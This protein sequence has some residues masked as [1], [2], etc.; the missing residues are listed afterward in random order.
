MPKLIR[1]AMLRIDNHF[2]HFLPVMARIDLRQLREI[3]PE[4]H[5]WFTDCYRP[6]GVVPPFI[7]GFD[8]VKLWD[9][10][11]E[12]VQKA[13]TLFPTP[14]V[15]CAERRE[16]TRDVDA[17]FINN[18]DLD[19]SDH[20]RLAEPFIKRGIPTYIDKPFALSTRDAVAMVKLARRHRTPIYSSSL[21]SVVDQVENMR[22]E[23]KQIGKR[24][25]AG[26]V[27]GAPGWATES[28]QEGVIHGISLLQGIFGYGAQW[29]LS[30]GRYPSQYA[31][32][33][34]DSGLEVSM[35]LNNGIAGY[36]AE[37]FGSNRDP[38]KRCLYSGMVGNTDFALGASVIAGRF[39]KMIRTGKPPR[40]YDEMIENI[41]VC[42]AARKSWKLGRKVKIAEVWKR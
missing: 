35:A 1:L 3:S 36:T 21:L 40:D 31:V 10:Q 39:L 28:G 5:Y 19:G 4:C 7:D 23:L 15:A 2:H 9:H 14:P 25:T 32:I 29:A 17:A 8:V 30:F 22:R 27:A 6:F 33:G 12:K 20:R 24:V 38:H 16:L 34:Y 18:C 11:P 42:E 41:A 13:L 26:V 37:A